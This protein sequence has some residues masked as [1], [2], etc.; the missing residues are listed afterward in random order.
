VEDDVFVGMQSLVFKTHV[1]AGVV[2]EPGCKLIGVTI[3][4]GR[5]VPAGSV[6]TLQTEADLLPTITEDY[7]FRTIN[8]AVVHVNTSLAEAYSVRPGSGKH[9]P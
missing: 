2:I 1:G 8:E 5:Y 9:Q 6:I 4:P 3:P 7:G